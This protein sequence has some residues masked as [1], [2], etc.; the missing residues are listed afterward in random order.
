MAASIIR[1]VFDELLGRGAPAE[2]LRIGA[3]VLAVE[4]Q[5]LQAGGLQVVV[6]EARANLAAREEEAAKLQAA[7]KRLAEL[8]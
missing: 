3:D 7:L 6:D 2:L 4:L 5:A 8:G 1:P